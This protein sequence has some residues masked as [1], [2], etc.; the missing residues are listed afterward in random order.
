MTMMKNSAENVP[1]TYCDN[2]AVP[3]TEPPVCQEHM[4]LVKKSA[5]DTGPE[6]L[7]EMLN[8]D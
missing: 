1:C 7:K 2:D 8:A 3:G 5:E 6:T 4:E